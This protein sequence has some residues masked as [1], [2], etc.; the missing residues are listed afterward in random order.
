VI[1]FFSFCAIRFVYQKTIILRRM[2]DVIDG[3][4]IKI[5]KMG[6]LEFIGKIEK[7]VCFVYGPFGMNRTKIAILICFISC[8]KFQRF[9]IIYK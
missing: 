8:R 7:T 2:E 9:W 6:E 5:I 1:G 4:N 3:I